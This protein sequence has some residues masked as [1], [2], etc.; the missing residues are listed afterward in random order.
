ML[1]KD[2]VEKAIASVQKQIDNIIQQYAT[3]GAPVLSGLHPDH[4]PLIQAI[5]VRDLLRREM[6][7]R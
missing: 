3:T 4:N 6:P 1:T 5:T 7:A 2:T